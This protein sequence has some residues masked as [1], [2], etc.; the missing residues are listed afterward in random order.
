MTA[1]TVSVLKLNV[2]PAE[3]RFD[4][5]VKELGLYSAL[6]LFFEIFFRA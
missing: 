1:G 6:L 5:L 3:G 2:Q 4:Q